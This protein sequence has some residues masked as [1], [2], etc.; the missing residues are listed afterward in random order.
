M[1]PTVGNPGNSADSSGYIADL[2]SNGIQSVG[3]DSWRRCRVSVVFRQME[4]ER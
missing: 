2:N 4:D 3:R 1:T